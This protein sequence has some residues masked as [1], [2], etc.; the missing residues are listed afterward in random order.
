MAV[1]SVL[2]H[3]VISIQ[4]ELSKQNNLENLSN[5]VHAANQ[6]N[7]LTKFEKQK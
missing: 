1:C 7:P 6:Q 2:K 3:M 5:E 4:H